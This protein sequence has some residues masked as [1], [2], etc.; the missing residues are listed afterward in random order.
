MGLH[1]GRVFGA[2]F[3]VIALDLD[4]QGAREWAD[5]NIPPTPVRNLS[6]KGEHRLYQHPPGVVVRNRVKVRVHGIRIDLD[7]RGD[8]GNLAIAPSIHP[9][10]ARYVA[11]ER[12]T[13][14]ALAAMPMWD[15][16]WIPTEQPTPPAPSRSTSQDDDKLRER[17]RLLALRWQVSD[18]GAGQ[19]TDTFKLA[20]YLLHCIGLTEPA[21]F[22]V[23]WDHY[24]QR[25]PE[26]YTEDLLRRKVQ[27]ANT[28][29]RNRGLGK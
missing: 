5:A 17:G 7:L 11:P 8:G 12:W 21:A 24:N 19:G 14:A 4:S 3:H 9:S 18:R 20:G 28:A 26:P 15:P 2:R 25:C 23:M 16:L 10:G 22:D 1:T 6:P 29:I 27:Q 13:A